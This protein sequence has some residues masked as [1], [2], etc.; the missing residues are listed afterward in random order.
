VLHE[1]GGGDALRLLLYSRVL[2]SLFE[3]GR[4]CGGLVAV[5]ADGRTRQQG[6][7]GLSAWGYRFVPSTRRSPTVIRESIS[8]RSGA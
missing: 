5:P 2:P 7:G 3:R 6:R 1:G 4:H 8:F